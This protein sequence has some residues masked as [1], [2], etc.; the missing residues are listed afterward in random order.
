MYINIY[1]NWLPHANVNDKLS[2]ARDVAVGLLF[3]I[4][5]IHF[6]DKQ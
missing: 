5:F 6:D 2:H 4:N 3:I 1:P